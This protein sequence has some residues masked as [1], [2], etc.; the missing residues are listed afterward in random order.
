MAQALKAK[1][2]IGL[3]GGGVIAN[4]I[5]K[6]YE[7]DPASSTA[8]SQKPSA[9]HRHSESRAKKAPPFLLAKV[10]DLNDGASLDSNIQL[11][12]NNAIV[13]AQV[14]VELSKLQVAAG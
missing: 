5:P 8:P 4:P 3:H 2:D 14:A 7:M 13:G 10:K 6:E 11:V 1:W 12:Y 9:N